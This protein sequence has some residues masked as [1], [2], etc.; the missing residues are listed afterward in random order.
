MPG[1]WKSIDELEDNVTLSELERLLTAANKMKN[2]DRKFFAA[3]KGIK[4]D[5]ATS[6]K[7][8]F[9]EIQ[10]RAQARLLGKTEE[11]L[12]L[13]ELGFTVISGDDE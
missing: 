1:S 4:W 12:D 11:E 13:G 9:E 8:S 6:E 7:S 5:D 10:K 2:N 3:M